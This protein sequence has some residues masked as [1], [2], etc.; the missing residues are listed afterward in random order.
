MAEHG[1]R[2]GSS[3]KGQAQVLDLNP[4]T[5]HT[6]PPKKKKKKKRK[7]MAEPGYKCKSAWFQS[8]NFNHYA[9]ATRRRRKKNTIS[10]VQSTSTFCKKK[11]DF[12]KSSN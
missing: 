9:I 3:S 8:L 2:C 5:T 12:H 10:Q 7:E 1:W 11:R 4:S 6:H